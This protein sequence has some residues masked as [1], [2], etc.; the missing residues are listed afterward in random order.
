M[1]PKQKRLAAVKAAQAIIARV[2]P[3][4]PVDQ[5]SGLTRR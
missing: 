4:S 3:F 2:G 1:D 5:G